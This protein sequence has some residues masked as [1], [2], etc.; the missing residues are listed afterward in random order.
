[1]VKH[2]VRLIVAVALAALTAG[3][4][5]PE[6]PL[7]LGFK[8]VPSDVVLGD[9]KAPVAQ[10]TAPDSRQDPLF[11]LPPSVVALPPPRFDDV[12]RPVVVPPPAPSCPTAD[13]LQAPA[14]EAPTTIDSPPADAV[15]L[16]RNSGTF[17]VSGARPRRGSFPPDSYRTVK[18]IFRSDDGRVFDF[19]V[20]EVI[21]GITT[22]TT[23]RV[24]KSD[25]LGTAPSGTAEAGI[26]IRQVESTTA[27]GGAASFTPTPEL[28]L[29]ALPLVRGARVES[30]G[31]DPTTATAMSFA[32]TVTGKARVDACGEPLDSF[33]VELTD[34]RLLAPDQDLQFAATYALGT[35]F[36]GL[37]LRDTVAFT[38]TD[39][40]AG[41][42][43]K[44][45]STISQ[46]PRRSPA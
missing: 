34:G 38:G 39:G 14:R 8:E 37:V 26:Y 6:R 11:P 45:T 19:S 2:R 28:R 7:R 18:T 24:V 5:A 25:D 23:Y 42:S 9:Q 17:D 4:G 22:T 41:V 13:P 20:A 44:K 29:A 1:M 12:R 10:A 40:D 16:F 31:V 27:D 21:T 46:V 15:Y 35:Q 32:A 30:R 3:C 36:G 33:T 43:R